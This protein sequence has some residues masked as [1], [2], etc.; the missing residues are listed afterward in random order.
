MDPW[1]TYIRERFPILTFGA[2][3]AGIASS[4]IYLKRG[5][6]QGAPFIFSFIGIF[7]F[8]WLWRLIDDI[9]DFE[10]DLIA[11]KERPLSR[12]AIKKEAILKAIDFFQIFLFSYALFIWVFIGSYPALAYVCLAVYV[13]LFYKDFGMP[14]WLLRHPLVKALSRQIVIFPLAVFAALAGHPKDIFAQH[15]WAFALML[16]GAF[17]CYEICRK[18][19]PHMHPV[20]VTFVQ[21]YGFRRTFEIAALALALSALGA[22]VLH[23][24][25][26]LLP[27]EMIVLFA[28]AL[29]LFQPALFRL[30]EVAASLSLM[31]HAWAVTLYRF[32]Q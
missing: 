4:G 24:T 29:L 9:K 31:A 28:M 2:L 5:A 13:W 3:A 26:L 23:L 16:F 6:F 11:Y 8:F 20:L 27:C 19:N 30:P 14:R 1:I 15:T 22:Y 18:L 25:P 17:F 32:F 21:F 12:G 7:V 10:K